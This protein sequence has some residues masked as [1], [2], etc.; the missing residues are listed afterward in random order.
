MMKIRVVRVGMDQWFVLVRMRMG[1][2]AIPCKCVRVLM[3]FVVRMQMLMLE[4]FMR[5]FVRMVLA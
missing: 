4:H 3:M 2:T 5:V 1:L